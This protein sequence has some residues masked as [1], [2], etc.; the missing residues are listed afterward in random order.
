MRVVRHPISPLARI[1]SVIIR[2]AAAASAVLLGAENNRMHV[3][4][5]DVYAA[6][7]LQT[8]TDSYAEIPEGIRSH[9]LGQV[10]HRVMTEAAIWTKRK[11]YA[12]HVVSQFRYL[13]THSGYVYTKWTDSE[14]A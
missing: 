11:C 2:N 13:T 14:S 12:A 7:D 9:L 8:I 4:L 10:M 1:W 3:D 6:G 5:E